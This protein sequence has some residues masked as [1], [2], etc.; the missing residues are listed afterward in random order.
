M[1]SYTTHMCNIHQELCIWPVLCWHFMWCVMCVNIW[2]YRMNHR[3]L[4]AKWWQIKVHFL[5]YTLYM[6]MSCWKCVFTCV[7]QCVCL[8][9]Y[10]P[11]LALIA[12]N[13]EV[14]EQNV[15][16]T[17]ENAYVSLHTPQN[18]HTVSM[19]VLLLPLPYKQCAWYNP[20]EKLPLT[21]IKP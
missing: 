14:W 19:F 13:T 20:N 17:Y 2:R 1:G 15:V 18:M 12:I 5:W 6:H 7:Y 9:V 10:I 3:M 16:Y 11:H 21:G 8:F 4:V